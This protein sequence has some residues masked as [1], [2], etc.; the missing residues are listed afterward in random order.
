[1]DRAN[2]LEVMLEDLERIAG[3]AGGRR[4]TSEPSQTVT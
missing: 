4:P 2:S 3:A 1:M